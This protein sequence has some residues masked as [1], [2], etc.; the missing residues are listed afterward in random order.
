MPSRASRP[1]TQVEWKQAARS[2]AT[3]CAMHQWPF[4][5]A[6]HPDLCQLFPGIQESPCL[7]V[8]H[9]RL[10]SAGHMAAGLAHQLLHALLSSLPVGMGVSWAPSQPGSSACDAGAQSHAVASGA[11]CQ[12][13]RGQS[14]WRTEGGE[15]AGPG[16]CFPVSD[17]GPCRRPPLLCPGPKESQW[18]I[19][20]AASV[21]QSQL[22]SHC[23]A[24]PIASPWGTKEGGLSAPWDPISKPRDPSAGPVGPLL[25][26]LRAPGTHPPHM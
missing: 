4:I 14:H 22:L 1:R 17:P 9:G 16:L 26:C 21:S 18:L 12:L 13:C 7:L 3:S 25:G 24:S 8:T 6:A 23:R 11:S 19:G 5:S 20:A 10:S 15:D 2:K